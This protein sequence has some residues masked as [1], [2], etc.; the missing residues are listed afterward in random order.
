MNWR[1]RPL[2]S[3]EVIINTI[4]ATTTRTGLKI[5]ATLDQ[6]A[7]PKGVKI[8]DRQ[9]RELE[10]TRLTRDPWHGEWNYCLHPPTTPDDHDTPTKDI[11]S[12]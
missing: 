1:G 6:A 10:T 4:G 11:D 3:H 5:Q 2:T 7:Y 9:M 8:S 12:S